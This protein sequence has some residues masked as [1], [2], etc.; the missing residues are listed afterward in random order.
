[1]HTQHTD[2]KHDVNLQN[3]S[4]RLMVLCYYWLE[5][6]IMLDHFIAFSLVIRAHLSSYS[7]C[8]REFL[9][10]KLLIFTKRCEKR[11]ENKREQAKAGGI[12]WTKEKNENRPKEKRKDGS[13]K[14]PSPATAIRLNNNFS[15]KFCAIKTT[16]NFIGVA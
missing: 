11:G 14:N 12:V 1:M 10:S 4:L 6:V 9:S 16:V 15:Y 2:A 5:F 3:E 8:V 7:R 13:T